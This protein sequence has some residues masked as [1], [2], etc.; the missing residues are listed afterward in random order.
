MAV[1]YNV[2]A[3]VTKAQSLVDLKVALDELARIM[4]GEAPRE[5]STQQAI[6]MWRAAGDGV[7]LAAQNLQTHTN[8]L[9]SSW[10]TP[11]N[12]PQFE[13]SIQRSRASLNDASGRIAAQEGTNENGGVATMLTQ[14]VTAIQQARKEVTETGNEAR[15]RIATAQQ[16]VDN[17]M[18]DPGVV[19][20]EE[21]EKPH[22][23]SIRPVAA[24][25]G[26]ALNLLG[27]IYEA[28]GKAITSAAEGL[29]WDGPGAEPGAGGPRSAAP[30]GAPN[31]A[32]TDPGQGADPGGAA[33]ED[34][35]PGGAPAGADPGAG[36][37]P[38][39]PE[40][41]GLAG[42]PTAP[43]LPPPT[44]VPMP[45]PGPTPSPGPVIPPGG[46]LPITNTPPRTN[47]P[48][49]VGGGRGGGPSGLGGLTGGPGGTGK[50]GVDPRTPQGPVRAGQQV[51]ATAQPATGAPPAAPSSGSTAGTTTAGSA[52]GAP[53]PMMP[54][55]AGGGGGGRGGKPGGGT[56][57]PINRKRKSQE[58]ETPGVPAGLRGRS[59][60]SLPGAFPM[61][62]ATTR[63]RKDE[64]EKP[65]D[66]L[67]L[68]D[69]ELWT[70]EETPVSDQQQPGRLAT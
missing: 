67:Q 19:T 57:R 55:M 12:A 25:G 34:A 33:P 3:G 59:G 35:A 32:G 16:I 26:Q 11:D 52:G 10:R 31:T 58:G 65:A 27:T 30:G 18:L 36:G 45:P 43:T 48:S 49:G 6:A 4:N 54:P 56:I 37:A 24:R 68:L 15:T 21:L 47:L 40:G 51:Q 5:A 20:R 2:V 1:D 14:V 66:T 9:M 23:D 29:K 63:R 44:T 41:P 22:V 69:E 46:I 38:T 13:A 7:Q 42:M 61:V 53:P 62:P 39:T 17:I 28:T 8:D 50:G 60:R 70:I 64:R